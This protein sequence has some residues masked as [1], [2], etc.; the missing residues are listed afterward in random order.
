MKK[1]LLSIVLMAVTGITA[2]AQSGVVVDSPL[3][4]QNYG[5]D[6]YGDPVSDSTAKTKK[7]RKFQL[8]IN[9]GGGFAN[10]AS[11]GPFHT[12]IGGAAFV[13]LS[14]KFIVNK[15]ISIQ[16][17]IGLT[18][19]EWK[20]SSNDYPDNYSYTYTNSVDV[21]ILLGYKFGSKKLTLTALTGP[22][23]S[24][25]MNKDVAYYHSSQGIIP[26]AIK[27]KSQSY[28]WVAGAGLSYKRASFDARYI[29]GLNNISASGYD[30]K[31]NRVNLSLGYRVL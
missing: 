31:L 1:I 14:G 4:K 11:N 25:F 24:F 30:Q 10:L 28:S 2:N 20:Y 19:E 16:P 18:R 15:F 26:V 21:P 13:S 29:L 27:F 22:M 23:A 9:L 7:S 8:T 5:M 6:S 3:L 17:E 12:K